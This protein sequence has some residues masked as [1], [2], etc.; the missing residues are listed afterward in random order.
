MSAVL[1]AAAQAALPAEGAGMA[2]VALAL[3]HRFG[4]ADIVDTPSRRRLLALVAERPGIGIADAARVLGVNIKT[5]VYHARILQGARALVMAQDAS[6]RIYLYPP[7][8]RPKD[9]VVAPALRQVLEAVRRAPGLS[10]ASLARRL[11]AP[12]PTV[13]LRLERLEAAGLVRSR[14]HGLLRIYEP[15]EPPR[16][17][18]GPLR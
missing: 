11:G 10:Q 3:Y 16:G 4:P 8:G 18:D 12:R 13:R 5:I 9:G 15:T 6:K 7:G 2:A 17:A 14:P 1:A